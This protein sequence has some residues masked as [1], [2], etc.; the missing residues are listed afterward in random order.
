MSR[1]PL[2]RRSFLRRSLLQA[3][4]ACLL[5]GSHF[6]TWLWGQ[7]AAAPE[8]GAAPSPKGALRPLGYRVEDVIAHSG[9]E[10]HHV[11]GGTVSK[12]YI[13]ETTGSG[14]AFIDYDNDGWP[15]IF[16][17]NGARLDEAPGPAKPGNRLFHN[18]RDGTFT[19]VTVRAGLSRSGWGQGVCIGDYDNDGF[20]DIY[21][22]YWGR[23]FST[24]TTEMARSPM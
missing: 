24:T 18:N 17:V 16:L 9:I 2:N 14:V 8:V 4:S 22:T 7:A 21:V 13:L 6:S 1:G 12:K 15:D 11:C 3:A 19:D 5:T 23:T 20:D 10:F